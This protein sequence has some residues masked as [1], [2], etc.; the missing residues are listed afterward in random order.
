MSRP[1]ATPA[2]PFERPGVLGLAPQLTALLADGRITRIRTLTGDPAWLVTRHEDVRALF[3]DDRLGRCHPDPQRAPR[4]SQSTLLEAK[5]GIET[6]LADHGRMRRVLTPAFSAR[7]MMRLRPRV[8]QIVDEALDAMVAAGPPADL[9]HGLAVPV[10]VLVI[11]E[12]LGVPYA[13]RADFRRW[14][15]QLAHLTDRQAALDGQRQLFAYMSRLLDHKTVEPGEDVL[16]D[17]LAAREEEKLTEEEMI[18]FAS[19]LLFAGHETT[20]GRIGYGALLLL[21]NPGQYQQLRQEP[22]RVDAAVEE[23]LRL[24]MLGQTG[25]LPRYAAQDIDYGGVRIQAGELV[26]LS[27][28]AAN[29]DETVFAEPTAFDPGRA[30]NQH[31]SFGHGRRFCIGATLARIELR[32]V[33]SRLVERLPDLRLAVPLSQLA[34]RGEIATGGLS[35]LPVTWG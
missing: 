31:V 10:P 25:G 8:E 27:L 11:C 21:T 5:D 22:D 12:L 18:T 7:R 26:L 14:S 2:L 13:D 1:D 9:H 23:I 29:L 19:G 32:A 35:A 33:F 24:S 17:L 4:V 28:E 30:Q 34:V 3:N 6:E 20:V 15:E 16:S